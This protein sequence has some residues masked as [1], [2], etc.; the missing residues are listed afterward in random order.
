MTVPTMCSATARLL[1][2]RRRHGVEH[3]RRVGVAAHDEVHLQPLGGQVEQLRANAYPAAFAELLGA[4]ARHQRGRVVHE[5]PPPPMRQVLAQQRGHVVVPTRQEPRKQP[6]HLGGVP[7]LEAAQTAVRLPPERRQGG[8]TDLHPPVDSHRQV[9]TEEGVA[10]VRHRIDVPLQASG[11]PVAVPVETLE[12]KDRVVVAHPEPAG[13]SVGLQTGRV[14]DVVHRPGSVPGGD[15]ARPSRSH[16]GP[17]QQPAAAPTDPGGQGRQHCVG[18]GARGGRRPQRPT[19]RPGQRL[20]LAGLRLVDHLDGHVV[21]DGASVQLLECGQLLVPAGDH[22]LAATAHR[23]VVL[24]AEGM[25]QDVPAPGQS[26]LERVRCVV[27]AGVQDTGVPAGRVRAQRR[28]LVQDDQRAAWP[29]GQCRVGHRQADDP[30]ADDGDVSGALHVAHSAESSSNLVTR[31]GCR[32]T[33][34]RGTPR[35]LRCRPRGRS[36]SA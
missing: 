5:V 31:A 21:G 30:A 23:D 33:W 29:T 10:R 35:C 26:R 3:V 34:S 2:H 36:R 4:D 9:H 1:V 12:R 27:E 14:H 8:R 24:V 15:G 17:E 28:L 13:H 16:L 25:Q 7:Q 19:R 20:E 6:G 11:R 22:E 32:R 18:R